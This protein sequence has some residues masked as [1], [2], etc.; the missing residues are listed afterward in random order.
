MFGE[1]RGGFEIHGERRITA[2]RSRVWAALMDQEMLRIAIPG[3][4]QLT[5]T[6]DASYA[7]RVKVGISA[8]RGTY[9]GSVRMSEAQPGHSYRLVAS[10]AGMGG[11]A[12]GD[13]VITLVEDWDGTVVRYQADVKARGAIARSGTVVNPLIVSGQLHGGIAQGIGQALIEE[14]VCDDDG[15]LVTGSFMDY[16]IARASDFPRFELSHT[17]TRS[18]VNPLGAKGIGE[19]GT[20]GS[21]PTIVN[22]VVDS[23][24]PFGV[25]HVD[26]M[27]RPEKVWRLMQ[28]GAS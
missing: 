1:S 28:G 19:A 17:E 16:A 7:L 3:C 26:L 24:S 25:K 15:Q 9:D 10:G 8:I 21:T 18:P 27:L 2:E 13:A 12:E 23:L 5:A 4:E 20:I 14:V 6:A 22:A 11:G